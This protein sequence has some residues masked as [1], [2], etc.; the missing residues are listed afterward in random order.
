MG[1]MMDGFKERMML[2]RSSGA[3][4]LSIEGIVGVFWGL[5]EGRGRRLS[6]S[7]GFGCEGLKSFGGRFGTRTA[8]LCSLVRNA[9]FCEMK[10]GWI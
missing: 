4:R 10:D 9:F 6:G 5:S 8:T 3:E 2:G 7:P 1:R